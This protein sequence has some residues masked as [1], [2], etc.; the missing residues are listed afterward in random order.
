ICIPGMP[1]CMPGIPICFPGI[2]ICMPGMPICMPGM[3]I[4]MP[5]MPICIPGIPI[6]MPGIVPVIFIAA[7]IAAFCLFIAAVWALVGGRSEF[8][9]IIM[10]LRNM[11]VATAVL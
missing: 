9:G 5:G 4:C 10:G 2:T 3:P 6:C 11:S 7:V 1:I 8:V